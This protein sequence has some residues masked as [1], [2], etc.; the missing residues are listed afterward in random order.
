DPEDAAARSYLGKAY[1]E[2]R[3]STE[4]G[5]ELARAKQADPN[6]PTP[7]FYDA[8]RLQNENRP[9]EALDEMRAAMDRN[10]QRAVYR[11]S[12]LLDQDL[13][14]RG[15][16]LARIYNDLGFEQVGLVAARRSAD[17]DQA[18]YSSHLFASG[19]YRALPGA[20]N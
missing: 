1:Y 3:R 20:A 11:S 15:A 14:A 2:L 10:G 16:D 6:D 17:L 18:N 9:V 19:N 8:I 4:A 12:L 13:A 7:H 5:K